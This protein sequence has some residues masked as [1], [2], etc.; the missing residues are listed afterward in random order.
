[1]PPPILPHLNWPMLESRMRS[2]H[3][4]VDDLMVLLL[5]HANWNAG[6]KAEVH[7]MA[8][9]LASASLGDQHLWQDLG[10]PSRAELS[11]LIERWFPALAALNHDNMRWKKFF[12]RQLCLKED[13]LI[14]KSPTCADCA[15]HGECFAVEVPAAALQLQSSTVAWNR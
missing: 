8:W 7:H 14:C 9:L 11:V 5:D 6:S 10:L 2:R 4:E 15:D 12:Y 13:V 1:M 3:D